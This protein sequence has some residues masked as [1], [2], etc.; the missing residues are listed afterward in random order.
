MSLDESERLLKNARD[1]DSMRNSFSLFLLELPIV[2]IGIV[3]FG[4]L[5]AGIFWLVRVLGSL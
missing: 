2:F 4:F 5:L 3:F 1:S